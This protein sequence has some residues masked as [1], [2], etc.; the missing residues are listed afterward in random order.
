MRKFTLFLA[1]MF[2]IGMQ[3]VQAQTRT[4][5]GTVTNA[6]DGSSIPGVSVVVKGTTY[7]TT[8]DLQGKYNLNVPADAK[9]LIFSFVGMKTTERNIGAESVIN[10][11]MEPE[12]TAIEG[13]VVTALGITREK[14]ALGYAVQD[15]GGD[16]ISKAQESNLVNSL[17]GK[18]SG[19]QITNSSGAVGS[20]SRIIIRG[21]KSFGDNQPLFV[22]DGVPVLNTAQAVDQYGGVDF[23]NAAMDIDPNSV[24]N[25]SVLKGANAAALYGSR[26]AN[27]V[28]LITTKKGMGKKAKG[29]IGV[30][31][32]SS[33]TF[34]NVYILPKYQDEYGQG[35]DGEEFVAAANGVNVSDLAAYQDWAENHSFSYYDGNWGGVNDGIDESWGPRLD[36]GLNLPQFNSPLSNPDDP[37]TRTATPWVSNPDN[38]KDFF[39][40]GYTY[41]NTLN[42]NGGNEK[43]AFRLGLSNHKQTG[44]IP[45]TDLMKNNISFSGT[46]NVTEKLTA[47][48]TANYTQNRSDNLP[49]GGYD[50]NNIMQSIGSWFG[51]QVDMNSLRDGWYKKDA[52][53]EPYNWNRSY[54]NNP[55]WTTYRNTT[56][57]TRDRVFGNVNLTY[58]FNDWLSLMGR[59]GTD[60]FNEERKHFTADKS[61]ESSSGGAFWVR[62]YFEQET[63]ADLI[64]TA[65]KKVTSDLSLDVNLGANYRNQ[66]GH[67]K[68]L[69][70]SELTV[71]DLYTIANVKGNASVSMYEYEKETNSLFGSASFGYKGYLYLDVTARN[72]WSSTLPP[73]AWSYF[74]PSVSLSFVFTELLKVDPSVLSYGKIR[75]SWA[76]VGK[77]TDPY[78]LYATYTPVA[79]PFNG[80]AQYFYSR[81]LPPLELKPEKSASTE[82]GVDLRFLNNRLGLDFTYYDVKTENQIMSV[83]ISNA[84]GFNNMKINAGEIQNSGVEIQLNAKIVDNPN[85][86]NWD[87]DINWSKNKNMVNKLYGDL[88]AY[89]M[90]TSWGGLTIEARPG[91]EFGIIRGGAFARD[92]KGNILVNPASGFRVKDPVP[93]NIGSVTPDWVGGIRNTFTYKSLSFSFL[94][95]GRMG[96]DLFS[97]TKWFG[98]YAGVTPKSV[99]GNVR[100]D[101]AVT[102]GVYGKLVNGEVVY[103]DADGN[104]TNSPVV[105]DIRVAAQ[106]YFANYWG[107]QEYGIIDGSYIKLR[108]IVLSYDLP[109][110]WVEKLGFLNNVNVSFIGRNLALLYTDESNDVGI[111]PETGFGTT[112]SGLGLEQYQLPPT[113]SLG[114]SLRL[115]F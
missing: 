98:D 27:G 10:V 106:D 61:I 43:G 66:R 62:E 5:T 50:E 35:F 20:S 28:V 41:I 57:R 3:V 23:G 36:I 51:R 17:S 75:G 65:N 85:G 80:V 40:T 91:E 58:K 84:S 89:Q 16:D 14:K 100:V 22:V 54:H 73:D 110:K 74:Y 77:D 37:D 24:E 46:L 47:Q 63:N 86:L 71:P 96:G 105:N 60:F 38:V 56:P 48:A 79:D 7:G 34:D 32:T 93:Q 4:I 94:I 15:L 29:G 13:V 6:E 64:L 83:N 55:Y 103:L 18:V 76:Q 26:A 101:G 8:T 31:F 30:D 114:F 81:T 108:E 42:I 33:V 90:T 1:L 97:V 92:D 52:F 82:F 44:A 78:G 109:T 11:A 95:D 72:D 104:E 12:V 107:I 115:N 53:G 87:L 68:Y 70:A 39:T 112:L 9:S 67:N 99:E 59:V 19:V 49:G 88:E 69:A 113:R 21:N 111:D 102:P 2:L 45:N 25:I